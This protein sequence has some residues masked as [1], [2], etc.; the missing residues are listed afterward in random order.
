MV[1]PEFF[2][3]EGVEAVL[4]NLQQRAG[5]T[6]I[7]T[8]PYV[9]APAA[10]GEGGREPPIDGGAGSVRVLDRPIFGRTALQGAHRAEL[11][12]GCHRCTP[13]LRY[14]PPVV[15]A[16]TR[17]RARIVADAVDAAKRRGLTVHLQVMAAIPPGVR[18]QF[19][20]PIDEDRPAAARRQPYRHASR[21]QR[22]AGQPAH[23]RLHTA[24]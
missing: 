1:L 7:A 3:N 9:M 20:G 24:R 15:D 4:D 19:G 8:S 17:R 5:A 14:R 18:V 23:P 2:Q 16:L 6:A 11:G 22:F 21:Q 13:G 10:D 12:A